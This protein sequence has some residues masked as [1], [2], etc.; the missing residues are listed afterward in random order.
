MNLCRPRET[1]I[2]TSNNISIGLKNTQ[3]WT[4]I[5]HTHDKWTIRRHNVVLEFNDTE[6]INKF[7]R[8][9]H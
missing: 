2:L 5:G 8:I 6:F 3:R 4:I 9:T 1:F 7:Y